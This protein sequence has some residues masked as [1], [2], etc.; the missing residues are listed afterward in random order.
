MASDF[1][2]VAGMSIYICPPAYSLVAADTS[3]EIKLVILR[4]GAKKEKLNIFHFAATST[5][6]SLKLCSP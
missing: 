2:I 3:S 4:K 6:V 1:L 5:K